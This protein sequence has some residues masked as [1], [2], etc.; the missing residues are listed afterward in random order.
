MK[1]VRYTR[2]GAPEV[3]R[4]EEVE[5]P[6]PGANELLVKVQAAT[7][8][9]GDLRMRAFKVPAA[10]WIFARLFLGIL[11]P[12]RQIPGMELAG[13]VESVGPGVTRFSPG[14]AVVASTLGAGFG[15]NAEYKVL[16][17][18]AI[19]AHKPAAVSF[20]AAAALPIG[21]ATALSVLRTAQIQP[22]HQVL[23][24]GASGS[25]GTFAVQIAAHMGAEVTG[26]CSTANVEL[27]RSLGAAHVLDYTAPGFALA[28]SAYEVVFDTV[29]KLPKTQAQ[30]AL[31]PSGIY[32]DMYFTRKE[33]VEELE[34][35]C[36]LAES[37]HLRTV[38][39]RTY[40]LEQIVEAHRYADL[41]HKKGNVILSVAP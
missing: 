5:T 35:V 40:P 30:Q 34:A 22:D 4:V 20:D 15:G 28:D 7:V 6:A 24:Y 41:G 1:A 2:Y 14:D 17:E 29:A 26:V 32:L 19:V 31:K 12:R 25:V 33:T 38:I 21:A 36:A 18:K 37:G 13:I 27:V 11:G 9:A 16:P 23:I 3:L 39:D 8:S 10:Q